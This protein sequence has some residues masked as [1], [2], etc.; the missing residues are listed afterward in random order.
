MPPQAQATAT[1]NPLLSLDLFP[2]YDSVLPTHV[3]PAMTALV[4]E[5]RSNVASLEADLGALCLLSPPLQYTRPVAANSRLTS[6]F[7]S[8]S[9]LISKRSCAACRPCVPRRDAWRQGRASLGRR[10]PPQGCKGCRSPPHCRDRGAFS[11]A[12]QKTSSPFTVILAGSCLP[13]DKCAGFPPA[14]ACTLMAVPTLIQLAA[15]VRMH[16]CSLML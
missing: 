6:L 14:W 1:N 13:D 9:P 2:Q 11:H 3:V 12:P 10:E 15:F 16:R 7:L 5:A 4:A 8:L